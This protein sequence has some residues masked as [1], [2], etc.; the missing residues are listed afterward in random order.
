MGFIQLMTAMLW[1]FQP[2]TLTVGDDDPPHS[3]SLQVWADPGTVDSGG[4]AIIHA[5]LMDTTTSM[6][7]AARR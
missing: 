6:G 1:I 2:L 7:S 3:F 4:G 5:Q